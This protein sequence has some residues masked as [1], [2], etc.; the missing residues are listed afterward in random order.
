MSRF[1]GVLRRVSDGLDLPQPTKSRILLEMGADLED[2]Y[3]HF[4][5]QGLDE[6]KA[7]GRAE[8]A[9][10]VSDEAL[11]HLAR[12]HQSGG[13]L[14]DRLLSQVGSLWAK[15]LLIL[16]VLAVLA[17]ASRVARVERFFEFV[18]P[19]IWPILG[20]ALAAFGVSLWKLF[21]LLRRRPDF[22]RLRLGLGTLLFAAASS[23]G[24]AAC[25]FFYHLRW[26]AYHSYEAA[27]EAFFAIMGRWTQAVSSM[28]VLGFLTSIL[29]GLAWF[30]L[31]SLVTRIEHRRAAALLAV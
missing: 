29:A 19:F 5:S 26:F 27:P 3:L 6:T 23:L 13:Q 25:G 2:A 30:T 21:E 28:M 12:I 14:A 10:V 9:F 22:R 11:K 15:I 4:R 24:L 20:L 1:A 31:S 8:E 18:S 7:V 17:I 16:W